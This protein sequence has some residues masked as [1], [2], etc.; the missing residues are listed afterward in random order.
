M[1]VVVLGKGALRQLLALG[2]PKLRACL[3]RCCGRAP[4]VVDHDEVCR[5]SPS[6]SPLPGCTLSHL[7]TPSHLAAP[8]HLAAPS[9]LATLPHLATPPHLAAFSH[10]TT[11][12]YLAAPPYQVEGLQKLEFE[13]SLGPHRG[14]CYEYNQMATSLT[15][16]LT[17]PT[18]SLYLLP[19]HLL[20]V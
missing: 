6:Y 8:P 4:N 15:Y 20:R 3:L 14:T 7:A 5:R 1:V 10:L 9:H 11:L 12:P 19:R 13:R 18:D 17:S 16:L 2:L